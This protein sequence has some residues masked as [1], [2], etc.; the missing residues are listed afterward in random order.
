VKDFIF[1]FF[2]EDHASGKILKLWYNVRV[3]LDV[4]LQVDV[5]V[6]PLKNLKLQKLYHCECE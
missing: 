1:K 5:L 4:G 2:I 6:I 3:G